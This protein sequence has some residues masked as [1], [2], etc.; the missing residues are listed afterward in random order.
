M[1]SI[2]PSIVP[3][4]PPYMDQSEMSYDFDGVLDGVIQ[5]HD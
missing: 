2:P 1:K 3:L 5:L 4:Q